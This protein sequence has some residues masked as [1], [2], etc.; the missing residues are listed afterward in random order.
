MWHI[1]DKADHINTLMTNNIIITKQ[2]KPTQCACLMSCVFCEYGL[3]FILI[4]MSNY[5]PSE[6]WD[7]ITYPFPNF[8]FTVEVLELHRWSFGMDKLFHFEHYKGCYL[9]TYLCCLDIDRFSHIFLGPPSEY[10]GYSTLDVNSRYSKSILQIAH[11]YH[12][13]SGP[14]VFPCPRICKIKWHRIL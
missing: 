2:T 4:W 3:T 14:R 5:M 13:F 11:Q 7:E 12:I 9:Y 8:N 10:M 1:T 6:V